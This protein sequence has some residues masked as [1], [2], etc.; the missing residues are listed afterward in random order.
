MKYQDYV[1]KNGKFIGKF[2]EM[3]QDIEDPW[4]QT[5]KN[6]VESNISRQVVCNYIKLFNIQS[7]AEFGCGLGKTAD[8]IKRNTNIEV[9]GIDISKTAIE[10]AQNNYPNIQ[11]IEDDISNITKY[12][13]CQCFFFSEITWYLLEN[14]KLDNLI[15]LIK[16]SL[17][18]KYLI[19]NLTF[20]KGQQK[21]G[22]EYFSDVDSFID[23]VPFKLI[24]KTIVD[25]QRLD[26]IESSLIFSI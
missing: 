18:G 4:N 8:F 5:K 25:H 20:Y 6:Y 10:K 21:Y 23:F 1:I 11:F 9:L 14:Q 7:I 13:D 2:E 17:K 3:Y 12:N 22:L 24:T 26:C 15:F 19:H 16:K